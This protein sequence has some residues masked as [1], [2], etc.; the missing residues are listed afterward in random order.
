MPAP[1]ETLSVL[2]EDNHCL[3]VAKPPGL[4]VAGDD[5]GDETLLDRARSYLKRKYAKPGDVFLGLVHRLDRPVSGVVLYARTSKAAGRLSEQFRSGS[6][7]KVYRAIVEAIPQPPEGELRDWLRKD[8]AR[9]QS[10]VVPPAT[11][12]ARDCRLNYRT[13]KTNASRFLALLEILPQTGRSHQIRVQL[14]HQGWPIVGDRKYG[15]QSEFDR[16][17]ALHACE[18]SFLHPTKKEPITVRVDPPS[19]WNRWV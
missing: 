4:L 19:A 8:E 15:A 13:L 5:T 10:E 6:V 7:R 14:S 16:S 17:I 1:F 3:A 18:L 9:N 2:F 12:G 11:P